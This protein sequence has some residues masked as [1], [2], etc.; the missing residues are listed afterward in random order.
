MGRFLE[1]FLRD[2]EPSEKQKKIFRR[3]GV[4]PFILGQL[5]GR[6][7]DGERAKK[8][9]KETPPWDAERRRYL[10]HVIEEGE[11]ARKQLEEILREMRRLEESEELGE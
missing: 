3:L 11:R 9:L 7:L 2:H 6:V 1:E 8:L 5:K 4:G 10:M